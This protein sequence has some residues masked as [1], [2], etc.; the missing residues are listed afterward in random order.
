M[1]TQFT[2]PEMGDIMSGTIAKILVSEGDS[3]QEETPILELE[4]DKA[5][6][7]VPCTVSG[8]VGKILVK[9]GD[10]LKVGD[11]VFDLVGASASTPA[12]AT[13][14]AS[15][16]AST[17]SGASNGAGTT[18]SQNAGPVAAQAAQQNGASQSAPSDAPPPAGAQEPAAPQ[19]SD[20]AQRVLIPAAPSVRRIARE[21]GVDIRQVKGSG[22]ESRISAQDVQNFARGVQPGAVPAAQPQ[23]AP[24]FAPVALP[25]FSKF[26]QVER[27]AMSGIRKATA[28]QMQ[29]A[30]SSV[31]H[32]TQ[33]D[34]IDI[35]SIEAM[36]KNYGKQ[37]EAAGGKLTVTA[38]MLKVVVSALKKFPAFN[39]AIDVEANE[40]VMKKYFHIGVAVDTPNGLLV[41][42][43]RDCDRKSV[44]ELAAELGEIAGKARDRKL[45]RDDMSGGS[46]TITNLGGIGGTHF[47]PIVNVPEVAILGLSRAS[48]E[49]VWNKETSEF[50]PRLM[51]PIS[52]SY[53]HRVI[54]GADGARFTR[55]LATMLE[56]PF[57]IALA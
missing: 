31:P 47:T 30:W 11:P 50:E 24:S 27:V 57:L 36:R 22:L 55:F 2:L 25:D 14:P 44:F 19:L 4:T 23:A 40:L 17:S 28:E 34:K 12:P 51:M 7:E 15:A 9:P 21:M 13:A 53:D 41:P 56:D 39:S 3:V 29:R 48:M 42:V 8:T 18:A 37:A 20:V 43:I 10:T 32:V 33:F 45:G 26:G 38:I 1:A 46:F 5:V 6:Q 52:L 54:D 35:T 16:P 49:P